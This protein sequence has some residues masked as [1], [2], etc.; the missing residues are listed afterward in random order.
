MGSDFLPLEKQFYKKKIHYCRPFPEQK[1]PKQKKLSFPKNPSV[2]IK[3]NSF[4]LIFL[5][6]RAFKPNKREKS[7]FSSQDYNQ[8]GENP[9]KQKSILHQ[10]SIS[11]SFSSVFFI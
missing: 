10:S 11:S 2:Q 1:K 8:N 5:L 7:Q 3:Q 9:L 4:L 6:K